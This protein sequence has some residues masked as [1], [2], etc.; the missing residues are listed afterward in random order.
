[1][2]TGPDGQSRPSENGKGVS[3]GRSVYDRIRHDIVLGVLRPNERLVEAD[4]GE[5]YSAS[6]TPVREALVRLREIGLV[7][8]LR[9][10]WC[11]REQTEQ[12]V[13]EIYAVRAILEGGA[14][15]VGARLAAQGGLPDETLRQL[16]E[17]AAG[18]EGRLVP[19]VPSYIE[20]VEENERFHDQ[21]IA[22][23]RNER[24][25]RLC[26]RE[27]AYYFN[28]QLAS[29]Y[30]EADYRHQSGQH[31]ALVTAV[32]AGDAAKA[33][34]IA[35]THVLDALSLVLQKLFHGQAEGEPAMAA[36][37]PDAAGG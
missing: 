5:R 34:E 30:S 27:R 36:L 1:M 26:Q 9:S 25:L 16:R 32:L 22:V 37:K 18:L 29:L 2:D 31:L 28:F 12:E 8:Q 4:L 11:V 21:L 7:E 20:I 6:R 24:L 13:R 19:E 23:A 14:A 15:R 17:T 10:G 3:L 33:E 35:V